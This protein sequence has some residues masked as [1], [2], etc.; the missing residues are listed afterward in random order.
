MQ[1]TSD[2]RAPLLGETND[3]DAIPVAP[4]IEE[5]REHL[6]A[7]L[8][9]ALSWQSLIE[10][11][12]NLALV[13]PIVL[14]WRERNNKA[15][16]FAF[17]QVRCHFLEEAAQDI[18][19]IKLHETRAE[20]CQLVASRLL[21]SFSMRELI[22]VLTYDF[23]PTQSDP[24]RD[25]TARGGKKVERFNCLELAIEGRAKYFVS[26]SLVQE[27]LIVQWHI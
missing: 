14:D 7:N 19:N 3:L 12:I 25:L 1:S 9:T 23:A 2:E 8:D 15:C 22:D 26:N 4:L 18:G 16:V 27:V 24:P 21:R 17:L 6:E 5:I 11:N 13:R 20:I 10:P